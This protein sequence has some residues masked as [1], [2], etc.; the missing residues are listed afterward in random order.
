MKVFSESIRIAVILAVTAASLYW[1]PQANASPMAD[2]ERLMPQRTIVSHYEGQDLGGLVVNARGKLTFFYIDDRLADALRRRQREERD[3]G[4]LSEIPR[5]VF[6]YATKSKRGHVIFIARVQ[7]LKGWTFDPSMLSVGGFSPAGEDI[8]TGIS[9]NPIFELEFAER[10]LPVGYDG[11]IGF[12]VPV[13]NA[14]RG[15][16]INLG[17]AS[18]LVDWQVPDR[19][20]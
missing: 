19:N 15:E 11:F 8:I 7:A 14:P 18:D 4:E 10:A 6:G 13:G 5:Q 9:S 2:I 17:Y 12:F 3:R 20:Q 1:A 16:A